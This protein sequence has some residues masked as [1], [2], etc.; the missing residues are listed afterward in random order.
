VIDGGVEYIVSLGT[1]GEA[2]VLDEQEKNSIVKYTYL[3]VKKRV[4]V[5]VGIGGNNTKALIRELE[6]FQLDNAAAVLSVTPYYTKPSQEGIIAHYKALAKA[7]PKPIILY[8]VPSRTGRNLDAQTTIRIAN[9]IENV[10]GIK[11]ASGDVA[12]CMKILRDKPQD[13][14]VLSGDDALTLPLMACGIHGIISV[15]ANA[16][17]KEFSNMVRLCMKGNFEKSKTAKR[18]ADRSL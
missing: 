6:T 7:S 11:E 18:Y 9:E 15:A 10:A 2:S 13:F 5:V 8:N 3:K 12:Q 17:P 16:F 14:L 1:T 4:P